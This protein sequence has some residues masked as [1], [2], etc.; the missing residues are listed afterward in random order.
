MSWHRTAGTLVHD[1]ALE[2]S[3]SLRRAAEFRD[4]VGQRFILTVAKHLEILDLAGPFH[5]L[6]TVGERE[7]QKTLLVLPVHE[8]SAPQRRM[9]ILHK[10]EAIVAERRIQ[11][12]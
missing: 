11:L 4:G 5:Q 7:L 9:R 2:E 12:F 6:R 1:H 8:R 3:N 10:I